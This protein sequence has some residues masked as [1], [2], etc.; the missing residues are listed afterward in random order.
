MG[1][2]EKVVSMK[3]AFFDVSRGVKEYVNSDKRSCCA[4]AIQSFLAP[5]LLLSTPTGAQEMGLRLRLSTYWSAKNASPTGAQKMAKWFSLYG[6]PDK[7]G[8]AKSSISAEQYT[9]RTP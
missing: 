4:S 8:T 7:M 3:S 6:I 5:L 9:F 2:F 1:V